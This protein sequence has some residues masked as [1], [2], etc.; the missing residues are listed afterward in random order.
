MLL[1]DKKTLWTK[2]EGSTISSESFLKEAK[3]LISCGSKV[4]IGTDS[5]LRG[6]NCVFVTVIAFHDNSKKI[7]KFF[8]KRIRAENSKY[9]NLKNKITEEVSLSMQA[10][11]KI[12]D[13]SPSTPIE[14]HV[15]IGK[16][17]KNK[18]KVMLST[19]SGWVTGMGYDLKIKPESWAS[20]SIA[21]SFTK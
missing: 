8:Y 5:M 9:R 2:P 14:L 10:A 12:N 7:A 21:D 17:Q 18:T 11:Q 19:V 20:S 1:L 6:D 4:Y 3:N 13:L 15:D 16:N